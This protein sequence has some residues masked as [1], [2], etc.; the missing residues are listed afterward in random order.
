MMPPKLLQS[1][2]FV[3]CIVLGIFELLVTILP[4]VVIAQNRTRRFTVTDDI[5]ITQVSSAVVF[6]PD[7]RFFIV[8]SDRGR[9]DVNRVESSL[10]V[11]STHDISHFLSQSNLQEE[12]SPLWSISKSTYKDGPIISNVQWLDDS[13]GFMFLAKTESGNDQLFLANP[14]TRTVKALTGEDQSVR[15]FVVHSEAQFVY[16]IPSSKAKARAQE[17]ERAAAVVGTGQTLDSLMF[18]K[19][20]TDFSDLC[21]LWAVVD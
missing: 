12:P 7:D 18:P 14:R 15:A 10:R 11:Y 6:S 4:E 19:K 1:R 9:I 5:G 8:E 17:W 3:A 16:A 13:S 21:E 20:S 2:V